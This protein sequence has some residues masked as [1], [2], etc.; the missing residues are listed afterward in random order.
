MSSKCTEIVRCSK[1]GFAH[2]ITLDDDTI[3]KQWACPTDCGRIN[4]AVLVTIGDRLAIL[5]R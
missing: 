4:R 2:V 3:V 5:S 1:C